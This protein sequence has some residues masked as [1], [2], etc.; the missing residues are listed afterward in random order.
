M[1][2][3][4][5]TT[6]TKADVLAQLR[7]HAEEDTIIKGNYWKDGKGCAVGCTIHSWDHAKYETHFGIPRMLAHLE[8]CIFEGL[9][10]D[11]AMAW[12][13]RFMET[14]RPGS[15][16]SLVG[17]KFLHWLLTDKTVNPGIDHSLVR[18]IVRQCADVL[19]PL[20]RGLDVDKSA[21][22]TAASA[23]REVTLKASWSMSIS[24]RE[25]AGMLSCES[26]GAAASAALGF[27]RDAADAARGAANSAWQATSVVTSTRKWA[28]S[29]AYVRMSDELIE[30][31]EEA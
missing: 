8:D 20:T 7:A 28:R 22:A 29:D 23:A 9:P 6:V 26:A 24:W 11:K 1:I 25:M 30:L 2:A 17:W 14:I 10:N 16:L 13:I 3:F 19:I 27:V 4:Q 15:D 31:I 5:D 12:P 18:D 21:A